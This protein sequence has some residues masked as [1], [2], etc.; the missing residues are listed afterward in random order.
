MLRYTRNDM[1][2]FR[3]RLTFGKGPELRFTGHLDL[4]RAW[5]RTVRRAKL[6]LA[7]S[8][9]YK[10]RPKINIGAALPL[11]CTSEADLVDVEL[12]TSP[13][14]GEL[15][16]RLGEAALP[17]LLVSRAEAIQA[18]SPKLQKLIT[19]SEYV[20]P[21]PGQNREDLHARIQAMLAAEKLLRVRR[22]R[23]Y[24]LRPLIEELSLADPMLLR[25]RL[26]ARSG[27]TGRPDEV[28]RA[29]ELNP[30]PLVPHRLRLILRD[31]S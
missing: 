3:Y 21:V 17:G 8:E 12:T 5:E 16:E 15:V 10:P 25:L 22:D 19:S 1:S 11:G 2:Y 27:A 18:G 9:G 4:Y 20:I 13:D 26:T 7:Y 24:D 30:D 29:L 6:P 31:L 14:P 28:L 23:K